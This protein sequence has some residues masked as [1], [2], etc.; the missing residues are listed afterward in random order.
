[1]GSTP[2]DQLCVRGDL[3]DVEPVGYS[4]CATVPAVRFEVGF[5]FATLVACHAIRR[6]IMST[7]IVVSKRIAPGAQDV[8]ADYEG[9]DPASDPSLL[10][11]AASLHRLHKKIVRE[12]RLQSTGKG[13]MLFHALRQPL[14]RLVRAWAPTQMYGPAV[15][16]AAS[17]PLWKQLLDQWLLATRFDFSY[18]SYYRYRLYRLNRV[19]DA[20]L[21]FPLNV[22]MAL[23]AHLYK[24]LDVDTAQLEE[25]RYFYRICAAHR[26]PVPVTVAEF[27]EGKAHAWSDVD[28]RIILPPCDLFSKPADALEG[29][30]VARW[31]W[32]KSGHYRGEGGK[33]LTEDELLGQ[34]ATLSRSGP[35]VLQERLTN[36]PAIA[37]LGPRA[38][39]TARIVTCQVAGGPPEHLV[40]IFRMPAATAK[41]VADNFAAGGFA[42]PIDHA[43]GTLGNA[44]R[45]DLRSAADDYFVYPGS[46][47]A[48]KAFRLPHWHAALELCLQAHRVFSQFPSV[49]WD[50]AITPDGPVLV[51]GNHDWD[52]VLAQQP[53]CRPLGRTRFVDS[54]LSFLR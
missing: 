16:H 46:T 8:A 50:V 41:S 9:A 48:L 51:E 27:S 28:D 44:V 14:A 33:T 49:G 4:A 45:K 32:D 7:G 13:K 38:L 52:V 43:T 10:Q 42:S 24:C 37:A 34:L 19:D 6:R 29:K 54:F 26:L 1:M 35:F 30:G 47:M 17:V 39:C 40:S 15:A 18:D 22:N 21:F 5:T 25:K 53:G 31:I 11:R 12:H 2:D 3:C 20:A 36:H 23:R